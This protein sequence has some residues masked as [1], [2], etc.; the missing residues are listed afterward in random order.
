[1]INEEIHRLSIAEH[2]LM[3]VLPQNE[4]RKSPKPALADSTVSRPPQLT[5][6][7]RG[8]RQAPGQSS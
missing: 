2:A 8:H 5:H 4:G 3:L 1:M 6:D 7:P